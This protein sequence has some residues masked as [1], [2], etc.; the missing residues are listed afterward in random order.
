MHRPNNPY[1]YKLQILTLLSPHNLSRLST[2]GIIRMQFAVTT[3]KLP[4]EQVL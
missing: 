2:S 1:R 3:D 4:L